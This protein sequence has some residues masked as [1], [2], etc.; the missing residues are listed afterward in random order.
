MD[1]VLI[2]FSCINCRWQQWTN[3][4][5]QLK[6]AKTIC[7]WENTGAVYFC[8]ALYCWSNCS[9][10]WLIWSCCFLRKD[11][12]WI[13]FCV[14]TSSKS[15]CN[16]K[17]SASRFFIVSACIQR[18]TLPPKTLP[19]CMQETLQSLQRFP[20]CIYILCSL[21][22]KYSYECDK[23]AYFDGRDHRPLSK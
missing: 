23:C 5:D 2:R 6:T 12:R 14:W 4:S 18:T 22:R 17:Y 21:T 7:H 3:I 11:P 19:L 15:R 9:V 10:N 1:R 16:L 8:L 13:S 20:N